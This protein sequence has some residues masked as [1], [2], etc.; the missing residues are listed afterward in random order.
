MS[1]PLATSYARAIRVA[2]R[3]ANR[4]GRIV[5]VAKFTHGFELL[6]AYDRRVWIALIPDGWRFD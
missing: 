4:T 6:R 1:N 3:R 5:Y 2:Q